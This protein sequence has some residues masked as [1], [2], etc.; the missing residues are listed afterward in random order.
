MIQYY[1]TH[2]RVTYLLLS[3]YNRSPERSLLL[4][5][6]IRADD[7]ERNMEMGRASYLLSTRP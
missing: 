7:R 5:I 3:F 4:E 6:K 2:V 1:E